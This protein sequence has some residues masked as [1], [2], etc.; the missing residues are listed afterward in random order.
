MTEANETEENLKE[1]VS[2]FSKEPPP[3]LSNSLLKIDKSILT[4]DKN[5][6]KSL[7]KSK[8][9][10]NDNAVKINTTQTNR[11]MTLRCWNCQNI[12]VVQAGWKVIQCP[13]CNKMNRVPKEKNQLEEILHYLKAN[14]VVSYSDN[15]HS[16]PL[17]N[18]FVMC[19]YCKTDNKIRETANHCI[20][21]S[22][23]NS[24]SL[25]KPSDIQEEDNQSMPLTQSNRS[26][27]QYYK[28]EKSRIVYPPERVL[29]FSDLFFPDPM[30]YPGYYP[31]NSL[32]PL[33]PEYYTPYDDKEYALRKE[34]IMNY[35]KSMLKYKLGQFNE[36]TPQKF[37]VMNQL[38]EID[39]KTDQLLANKIITPHPVSVSANL[40]D[41]IKAY[42]NT[43]FTKK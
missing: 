38:K 19:P 35:N 29:R 20:C 12:N 18:Y 39:R 31:I 28:Y 9:D 16:V 11:D 33:F 30:F 36:T 26:N 7:V 17:T 15:F 23:R 24:W 10:D 14:T 40:T 4:E 22:C 42:E 43:F 6:L 1:N 5:E 13:I 41:R 8:K 32:S 34:K 25:K 21:F 37:S 2:L 3:K 27:D